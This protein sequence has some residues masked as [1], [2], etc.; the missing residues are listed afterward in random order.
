MPR[1]IEFVQLEA[2][3]DAASVRDRLSF[4]RGQNVLLI[5]PEEGPALTRKLDLVLVQ[6]EAM[7]RAIRVALV[8]HDAQIIEHARELNIS[9]FETIG[10]S[11]RGRWKRGRGKVFANR[12]QKPEH[13]LEPDE[14]MDVASRVRVERNFAPMPLLIRLLLL[15]FVVGAL[16][17][18]VY[19]V[20]PGAVVSLV[21]AEQ[22]VTA[23]NV[24]VIAD[25]SVSSI[26][27]EGG[28]IPARVRRVEISEPGTRL[29]TGVTDLPDTRAT[30]TVAFINQSNER[31]EI[32]SDTIVWSTGEQARFRTTED[33]VLPAGNDQRVEV[34]VEALPESSGDAGNVGEG[35]INSV[36]T[37][38]S[39]Q[40]TVVNLLPLTGGESR[41]LPSVTES[42]RDRLLATVRQ[43]LFSRALT[44]L[45]G[46]MAENEF[47]IEETLRIAE[48]RE[49]T[50][51]A[52]VG[53]VVA[54][55]RLDMRVVIEAVVIDEQ[56]AHRIAFARMSRQIPRGR[57]LYPDSLS[58]TRGPVTDIDD[59]RIT[60]TISG[61]GRVAG[62]VDG[63]LL[64]ERLAGM[65]VDDAMTYLNN[66]VD[67]EPGTS[68]TI[69][70]RPDW[71]DRMP[72]LPVRISIRILTIADSN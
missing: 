40:V 42:D 52:E 63:I 39:E 71:F 69:D 44:E 12:A 5:W 67:L 22:I 10:A 68:P 35:A 49:Q 55:L 14:L 66:T 43:Q 50:F 16:T 53:E 61:S 58:Y 37:D 20:I 36:E 4:Y 33:A 72:L 64:R 59:N 34:R 57:A 47:L 41:S 30:G 9:T 18:T 23:D 3:E 28:I 62:Q 24:P 60:F 11:E 70:L 19:V 8:T 7:R 1:A 26:D 13:E 54:D 56:Q 45:R 25:P 29:T 32:P 48:V 46:P 51:S 2:G 38:W 17:A 65:T 21:L 31:I 6:R 15:L 27:I